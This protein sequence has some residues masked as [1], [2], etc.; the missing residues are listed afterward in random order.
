MSDTDVAFN[1]DDE[2]FRD[3]VG[4]FVILPIMERRIPIIADSAVEQGF[5]TGA[6]KITPAH[7]PTDFEIGDR[8]NLERIQVIGF[9]GRMTKEA[10]R[11]AGV[12]RLAAR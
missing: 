7:D 6:V 10:G 2:R 12:D 5:G 1:P 9:D 3:L 8:H 11:F 4:R